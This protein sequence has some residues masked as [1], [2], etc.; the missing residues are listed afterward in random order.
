MA[1]GQDKIYTI[2]ETMFLEMDN[3]RYSLFGDTYRSNDDSQ[4]LSYTEKLIKVQQGYSRVY[5]YAVKL[6]KENEQLKNEIE[7]L[8]LNP[9]KQKSNAGRRSKFN[10][11]QKQKI[12]YMRHY[13]SMDKI[14]KEMNCSKGLVHKII[15]EQDI[16]DK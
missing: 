12:M 4:T 8:R 2:I 5:D 10:D 16:T 9:P 13:L 3:A 1:R 14:A 11:E 7:E 15:H 6:L